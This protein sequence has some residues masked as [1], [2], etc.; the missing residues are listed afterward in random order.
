GGAGAWVTGGAA[1]RGGDAAR[2]AVMGT[3]RVGAGARLGERDSTAPDGV[4]ATIR[5][6]VAASLSLSPSRS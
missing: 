6:L 5:A 4:S 1:G 3:D 2:G